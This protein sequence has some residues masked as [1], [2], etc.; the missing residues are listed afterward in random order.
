MTVRTLTISVGGVVK[1]RSSRGRRTLA[2]RRDLI[3]LRSIDCKLSD[4]FPSIAAAVHR[5]P[6]KTQSSIV[7]SSPATRLASQTFTP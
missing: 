2:D 7:S 4:R 3:I 1:D 6:Q 5:R